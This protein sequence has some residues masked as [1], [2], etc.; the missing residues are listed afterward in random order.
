M[1]RK[2]RREPSY[3][4]CSKRAVENYQGIR[5]PHCQGGKGCAACWAKFNLVQHPPRARTI[6]CDTP[7]ALGVFRL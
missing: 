2:P 4:E 3:R 1:R 7:P 6:R 5:P